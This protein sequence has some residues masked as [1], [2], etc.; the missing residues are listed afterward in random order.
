[1]SLSSS[2]LGLRP[3]TAETRVRVPLKIKT[4]ETFKMK[5]SCVFFLIYDRKTKFIK[6]KPQNQTALMMVESAREEL[7]YA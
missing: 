7:W 1:M 5:R 6:N 4:D 3:F 2:W